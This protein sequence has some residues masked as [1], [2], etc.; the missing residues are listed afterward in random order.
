MKKF[1]QFLTIVSIALSV[2]GCASLLWDHG[3]KADM[4]KKK[5]EKEKSNEVLPAGLKDKRVSPVS[6]ESAKRTAMSRPR[7]VKV[8]VRQEK[9]FRGDRRK[10]GGRLCPG[11]RRT[12][13][14]D[15]SNHLRR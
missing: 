1:C 12:G 11:D 6:P 7:V 13:Q 15:P 14:S 9:I 10:I 2:G 5:R 3:D 4:T 8:E